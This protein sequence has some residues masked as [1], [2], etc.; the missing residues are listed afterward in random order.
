MHRMTSTQARHTRRAVLQ[1]AVEAGAACAQLGSLDPGE[2]FREDGEGI[3]VWRTRSRELLRVCK[4]CPVLNACQELAL[5]DGD[6]DQSSDELVRGG[7]TGQQLARSRARQTKR[8]AAAVAADQDT[9]WR[10][11]VDLTVQLHREAIK[12]PDK[13]GGQRRQAMAQAAQNTRVRELAAQVRQ[14]RSAR[15]TR[16]GWGV[17]A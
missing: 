1:A 12:N 14:I 17:A 9:E 15:R 8:L 5:R 11:L 10:E 3:G 13:A 16:T 4:G 7:M 2:W 6:G